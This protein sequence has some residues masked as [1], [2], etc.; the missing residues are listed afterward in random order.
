[1]LMQYFVLEFSAG[2]QGKVN[3]SVSM[4]CPLLSILVYSQGPRI[5]DLFHRP[6]FSMNINQSTKGP[7]SNSSVVVLSFV[8]SISNADRQ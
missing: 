5:L 1:M 4:L 6:F 3:S 2:I 7:D 8:V